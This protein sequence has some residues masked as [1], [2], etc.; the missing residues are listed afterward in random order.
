[1]T[2]LSSR[3]SRAD[4]APL[5]AVPAHPYHRQERERF[6]HLVLGRARPAPKSVGRGRSKRKVPVRLAPG[7]EEAVALREDWSHKQ[8]TAQTHARAGEGAIARLYRTGA[9]DSL[10]QVS[11]EQIAAAA[12]L[13]A[14]DVTVSIA[15]LEARVDV[16]RMGDGSFYEAL[17]RVRLEMAYSRWRE[18]LLGSAGPVLDMIV[19]DEAFTVVAKRYRMHNR[20]AKALLLAALDE[21]APILKHVCKLVDKE[22]LAAAQAA[23]L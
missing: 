20:R 5:P 21:W 22:T 17:G 13:I 23:I 16:T 2:E 10:Q 9:I 8:G 7:I 19:G 12:E 4:A 6:E 1:M 3:A 14:R 15:S 11:A 18:Q